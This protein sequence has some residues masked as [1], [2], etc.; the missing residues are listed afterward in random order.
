[1]DYMK[2]LLITITVFALAL[3]A[4]QDVLEEEY[5]NPE[6]VNP[7]EEKSV[8]GMFSGMLYQWQLFVKDYGEYWW[9]NSGWGIPNYAQVTHRYI[10]DRYY[11]YYVDYADVVTGV[12]GFDPSAVTNAFSYHYTKVK[13]WSLMKEKID[14]MS[15][16]EK[17]QVEVYYMLATVFKDMLALR[18][19]DFF[20]SIP[21]SEALQG[22]VGILYPKYDDP[23]EI[24]IS[25]LN[26]FK[27]V[28]DGLTAAYN[29]MNDD[30]KAFF[31]VQDVALQ[32]DILYGKESLAVVIHLVV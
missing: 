22:N 3:S 6:T 26:D 15:D 31:A 11:P 9:Q 25:I 27:D 19:V 8:S 18:S 21:Y 20:N 2:K 14:A 32:G 17:D 29:K 10:T 28:A 30:S 13:E 12:N 16:A 4:C 5:K 7:P 24:Y 1:M 23:K